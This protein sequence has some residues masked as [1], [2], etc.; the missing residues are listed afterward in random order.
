MQLL[1]CFIKLHLYEMFGYVHKSKTQIKCL[2]F[3]ECPPLLIKLLWCI[4]NFDW[5]KMASKMQPIAPD[6][7]KK[8]MV[9]DIPYVTMLYLQLSRFM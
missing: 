3:L 2:Y 1:P 5:A 7:K 6:L 4:Y 9:A 8:T